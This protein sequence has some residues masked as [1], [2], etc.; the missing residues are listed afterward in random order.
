M[1]P[2]SPFFYLLIFFSVVVHPGDAGSFTLLTPLA[3]IL[4]SYLGF[5]SRASGLTIA[6]FLFCESVVMVA[7]AYPD[8][9][10]FESGWLKDLSTTCIPVLR[11][12][13]EH[14]FQLMDSRAEKQKQLKPT[15][16][17]RLTRFDPYLV[18]V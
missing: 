12:R 9:L 16:T 14:L 18:A 6:G 2:L 4:A 3:L 15:H 17:S 7:R 13:E 11:Q 10:T 1:D 5:E 8:A